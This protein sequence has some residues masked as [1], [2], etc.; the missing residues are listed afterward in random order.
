MRTLPAVPAVKACRCFVLT[1]GVLVLFTFARSYG[2]LSSPIPGLSVGLLVAALTLIAWSSGATL[3]DLGLRPADMPAGLVY[4]AGACA[5]VLLVLVVA[6]VIPAAKGCCWASR[7]GR[8][9]QGIA[10]RLEGDHRQGTTRCP[11]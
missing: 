2:L 5:A 6:A 4:G 7:G 1:V 10:G 11:R 3:A 9:P 8:R